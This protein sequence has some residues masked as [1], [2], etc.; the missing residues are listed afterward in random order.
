LTLD[1]RHYWLIGASEGLGAA[2]AAELHRAGARLTL[3]ARSA[4]RLDRVAAPL[5]ADVLP[6][7]V[8]DAAATAE[9]AVRVGCPDGVI[10]A[11]GAYEPMSAAAWEPETAV[12]VAETNYI[13][14]LRVLGHAVPAMVRRGHGHVVLIGSLAGHAGLPGAIG[15]GSSK[16]ALMH[17]AADMLADLRGTGVRVQRINPGFIR[18]RLTARNRFRMPQIM[19]PEAAAGRVLD[20]MRSSRFSTSFPAPFAWLFTLSGL[21]PRPL[22]HRITTPNAPNGG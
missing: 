15:Y 5:G 9:A 13:G 11:V 1:G 4:G 3:S 2:L 7:D 20:A 12:R 18:T 10:Y 6:L 17:L 14:A 22:F 16:S 8:T 21:I 19:T